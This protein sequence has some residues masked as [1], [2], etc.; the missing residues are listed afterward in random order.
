MAHT[1]PR[2]VELNKEETRR[3]PRMDARQRSLYVVSD[4]THCAML[5]M[6][7][8]RH[9]APSP[10]TAASGRVY[11]AADG[12]LCC[13]VDGHHYCGSHMAYRSGRY[14]TVC[15]PQTYLYMMALISRGS[16]RRGVVLGSLLTFILDASRIV[17]SA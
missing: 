12:L 9:F 7:D 6:E 2:D 17:A 1:K 4:S 5:L 11:D 8:R 16:L 10:L 13:D 15:S 14:G 3:L